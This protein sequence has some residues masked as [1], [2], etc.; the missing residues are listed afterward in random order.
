MDRVFKENTSY[1]N[2]VIKERPLETGEYENCMFRDCDFSNSDLSEMNF[3]ECEF[4]NCNLSMVKLLNTTLREVRFVGCKLLGLH[5]EDCN[6]IM[7]SL[8]FKECT[9]TISSF[10][11]LKLR[12]TMFL[13]SIVNEVD[14]TGTDLSGSLFDGCDLKQ[15]TF[16][17]TNL[18]GV[19]FRTASGYSIDPEQNNIRKAKFSLHGLTGLLEKYNIDIEI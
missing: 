15:T 6:K 12:K 4:M 2:I 14:F 7:I 8:Y 3:V 10:Y 19:D 13:K 18:E 16:K 17:N 5:F 1:T 11:E 9:L